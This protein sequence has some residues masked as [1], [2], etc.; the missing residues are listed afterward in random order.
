MTFGVRVRRRACARDGRRSWRRCGSRG[1]S[2]WPAL[3]HQALRDSPRGE[4]PGDQA[5]TSAPR[6]GL[7][8]VG[9]TGVVS[10]FLA[11]GVERAADEWCWTGGASQRRLAARPA[12]DRGAGSPSAP[13]PVL[14][15]S[16]GARR[17]GRPSTDATAIGALV[18]GGR[19]RFVRG[20]RRRA[21]G[22]G[23]GRLTLMSKDAEEETARTRRPAAPVCD[24]ARVST[25][26]G[27]V[28]R[29]S[30]DEYDPSLATLTGS[31]SRPR[32][33]RRARRVAGTRRSRRER[34][35]PTCLGPES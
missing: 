7:R 16:R 21:P 31:S 4:A 34:S 35:A 3:N 5:R 30:I 13:A 8:F 33:S 12:P 17:A 23:L 19:F 1:S 27:A 28:R 2:R 29:L 15:R 25:G 14:G 6:S 22:I 9:G 18:A 24:N 20:G 11:A 32:R 26:T 10:F